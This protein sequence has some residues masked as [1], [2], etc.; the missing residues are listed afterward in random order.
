MAGAFT[1]KEFGKLRISRVRRDRFSRGMRSRSAEMQIVNPYSNVK[2]RNR[3]RTLLIAMQ[4]KKINSGNSTELQRAVRFPL[5]RTVAN[6]P[7]GIAQTLC[8]V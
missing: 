7:R 2:R 3:A 1:H 6:H 4:H 8:G 5:V